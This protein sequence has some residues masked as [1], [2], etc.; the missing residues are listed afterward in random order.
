MQAM[1]EQAMPSEAGFRNPAQRLW[2]AGADV[3]V[4]FYTL[5]LGLL[6]I[7]LTLITRKGWPT[8]VLTRIWS[9]WIVKTC[10]IDIE[11]RGLE[12]LDPN[13]RYVLLSNHLSNLDIPCKA[14]VLPTKLRFIAK[15]ELLHVPIFGQVLALSDHI[16]IDRGN[17][18]EAVDIINREATRSVNEGFW[19]VFYG[20]GTRSPDGKVHRFKKGG[21]VFALKTG[22]P[23]VP[24]SVSGTRKFM[25][26]RTFVV[27]PGGKVRIV[28]DR[29]IPTAG[30]SM[31]ERDRLTEQVREIVIR[32]YDE[33]L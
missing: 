30:V 10:G 11:V 21:V 22:L 25:P 23:I 27:R 19:V 7:G 24:V 2:G 4:C 20:E 6:C 28:L 33:S 9:R 3:L 14:A 26:K 29:P 13:G 16:V 12:Q 32:N 31:E 18:E 8:D 5:V 17:T 1:R 15:K